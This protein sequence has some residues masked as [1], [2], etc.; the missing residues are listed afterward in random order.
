M[1]TDAS[2]RRAA[3][4]APASDGGGRPGA[5]GALRNWRTAQP[6]ITTLARLA[7]AGVIGYAGWAKVTEPPAIQRQA[8]KA[9]QILPEG[10]AGTVGIGLPILELALAALLLLG[11]ATRFAGAACALLMIVFIGGII[12]VWSRG[13]SI[14]CGCFGGG[15]QVASGQTK[16]LQEILRDTGF[17]ALALWITVLPKSRLA[18]DRLLGLYDD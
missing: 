4:T 13:L 8:V 12:S 11:F 6:W 7:L 5:I 17:L 14:D 15:G 10:L 9:Y 2:K 16:Y 3:E 1:A 18:A